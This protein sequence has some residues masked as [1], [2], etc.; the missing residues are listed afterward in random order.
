MALMLLL[1]PEIA[2][3]SRQRVM[4]IAWLLSATSTLGLVAKHDQAKAKPIVLG[5]LSLG[6][7]PQ[8][9]STL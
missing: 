9:R 5:I 8:G 7:I 4:Q 1:P 2:R 6:R 3:W